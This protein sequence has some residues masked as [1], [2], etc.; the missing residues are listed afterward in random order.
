MENDRAA[1]AARQRVGAAGPGPET[2]KP[3]GRMELMTPDELEQVLAQAP[4]AFVPLGT[5]E[6]HGWH[7]PIGLDGI[8]A[9]G[10]CWRVAQRTGGTVP[11]LPTFF[12]GTGGGHEVGYKRRPRRWT[13]MLPERCGDLFRHFR[14]MA[15]RSRGTA[16]LRVRTGIGESSR[17]CRS[18]SWL[19]LP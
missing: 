14:I 16:S 12:Y 17:T 10:L 4:V 15:S 6:H 19:L 9:H 8:K 1:L 2:S 7:L 3:Y 11:T 13:L 18:T 5:Y